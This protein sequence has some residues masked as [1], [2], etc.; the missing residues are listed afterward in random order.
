MSVNMDMDDPVDYS[1]FRYQTLLAKLDLVPSGQGASIGGAITAEPLEGAGG[2]DNNEVAELVNLKVLATVEIEDETDDQ[3]V[4]TTGSLKGAIGANLPLNAQAFTEGGVDITGDSF[5][6]DNVGSSDVDG[7]SKV[8]DRLFDE[9]Q[10]SFGQPFDDEANGL[11]GGG[12]HENYLYSINYRNMT[13]RGPVLDSTDDI[14]IIQDINVS[15]SILL[16]SGETR[17]HMTWDI[18]EVSDAGR[19]FSVPR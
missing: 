6:L 10:V 5:D 7:S 4:A 8:D 3:D 13:G 12:S 15:D 17:V 16:T 19:A 18:A 14:T 2:L 1:D 11:G 9:Y